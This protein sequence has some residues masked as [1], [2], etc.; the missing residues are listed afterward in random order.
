MEIQ[1]WGAR[2][3]KQYY[4]QEYYKRL[5]A[6][7]PASADL[8]KPVDITMSEIVQ[9]VAQGPKDSGY[10]FVTI[11]P[12]CPT[13]LDTPFVRKFVKQVTKAMS[14]KWITEAI[15]AFEVRSREVDIAGTEE[16]P[17]HNILYGGLHVHCL[18][19]HD[20]KTYPSHHKREF[21]NTFK[22]YVG[23][24]KHVCIKYIKEADYPRVLAYINGEKDEEKLTM[25]GNDREFRNDFNLE[26]TYSKSSE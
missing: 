6:D 12:K 22:G 2:K 19:K 26:A 3:A 25:V 10:I 14:K 8:P 23:H 11:N 18:L 4:C 1:E 5:F 15:W 13:V 20:K 16:I 9:S 24:P 21:L 17:I 7:N